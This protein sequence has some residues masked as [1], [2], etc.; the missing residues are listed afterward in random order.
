MTWVREDG[1]VQEPRPRQHLPQGWLQARAQRDGLGPGMLGAAQRCPP[2]LWL[3]ALTAKLT[4][5]GPAQGICILAAVARL[6]WSLGKVGQ[7]STW[8]FPD[9]LFMS[10]AG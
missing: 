7:V 10:R 4:G 1:G 3:V 6:S 5:P 9:G 2:S 8:C